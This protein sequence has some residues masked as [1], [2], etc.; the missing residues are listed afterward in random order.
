MRILT[1]HGIAL[2]FALLAVPGSNLSAQDCAWCLDDLPSQTHLI[3]VR[4]PALNDWTCESKPG[5]QCD[6]CHNFY[7]PDWC[8]DTHYDYC[9]GPGKEDD[10]DADAILA[11]V[12]TEDLSSLEVA[13]AQQESLRFNER[14]GAL[15]LI[16]CEGS[17]VAHIPLPPAVGKFLAED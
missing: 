13:L 9:E 8:E 10:L 17:I 3:Y 14:R 4:T 16:G 15:Q 7:E 2:A 1:W 6:G 5:S 11:L 12:A